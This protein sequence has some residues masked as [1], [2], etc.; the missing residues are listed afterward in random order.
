MHVWH[1]RI[2]SIC[3]L[4]VLAACSSIPGLKDARQADFPGLRK[5]LEG[6][7]LQP[8]QVRTLAEATLS[9]EIVRAKDRQDRPFIRSLRACSGRLLNALEKRAQKKDGVGAEAALL[10]LESDRIKGA[11]TRYADEEDG[12]WRALSARAART[13]DELR[14]EY[15]TDDDQ[16]VRRAAL[17]AAR[18]AAEDADIEDLLE[19]ARLDPDPLTRSRAYQVLGHIGGE[20]VTLALRDR[21]E[22]ADEQMRLAIVDAWS[23]TGL[24][25]K[26]GRAHLARLLTHENGFDAL[27][28]ASVLAGDEDESLR[29]RALNRLIRFTKDG[30]TEERRMALRLLPV[31]ERDA[32]IRLLELTRVENEQVAVIAWARL[33]GHASHRAKAQK[34]LLAWAKSDSEVALQARSALSASGDERILP[35]MLE[36]MT[37]SAPQTRRVA[38]SALIRLG[39]FSEVAPLLADEDPEVRRYVACRVLARPPLPV[40]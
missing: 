19:V 8:R 11:A 2:A 4:G 26:G 40:K 31:S 15:F 6:Q 21:F 10:L 29:N 13:E 28:A 5:S 9:A 22:A 14:R 30:T 23:K 7:D 25:E 36:Q 17:L 34:K 27:H 3:A 18:E 20:R 24:Y 12:A 35:L 39:A 1:Y 33:L 32:R 38:G 37:S 16:R